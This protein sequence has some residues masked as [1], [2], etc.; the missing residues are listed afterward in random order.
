MSS[1]FNSP[2]TYAVRDYLLRITTVFILLLSIPL[3]LDYYNLLFTTSWK[4][5]LID[6]Y[7]LVTYLPH[8]FD[9]TSTILD[10]VI[11]LAISI[12][13]AVI[14]KWKQQTI[15][16]D[17]YY[18]YL[19]IFARYKLASI[20][21]VAGFIKLFPLYVPELS[22]SHLNTGYGYFQHWKHLLL[23]LSA[24]PAYLVFLGIVELIAAFFLLFRKTSFLGVIFIIPFYG[25]VFLADLAYEG[26]NFL[27][28]IFIIL[29]TLPVFFYDLGRLGNLIVNKILT[30]PTNWKFEWKLSKWK[31]H[32]LILKSLFVFIFIILVGYK[33]YSTYSNKQNLFY[34]EQNGINGITGKFFVKDFILNGDTISYSDSNKN[35]WK[36]VVFEKWNT[37][38]IRINDSIKVEEQHSSFWQRQDSLKDYEYTLV[39]DRLYYTVQLDS[40]K[41]IVT[42]KNRN[43]KYTDSYKFQF[44]QPDSS[45]ILLSGKNERGDSL[46]VFLVNADKKY[47]L[48][49]V[50]KTGRRRLGYK[51]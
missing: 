51:L 48:E 14:W 44:I 26:D 34:P 29:L 18:Y 17:K 33:S 13:I 16:L 6:L 37:L 3:Q 49:E 28:S 10:W 36:D 22:L 19:R 23:S 20:L 12:V 25:N 50:K 4:Y 38:S 2:K 42:L 31:K 1:L 7:N 8:Y 11:Y 5:F 45:S 41:S 21:L 24:A 46:E 40:S 43:T 35:R 32:R 15:N 9:K 39:G 30:N 47:L 27:V